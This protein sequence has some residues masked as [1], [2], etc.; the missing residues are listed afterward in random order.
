MKK[1][2]LTPLFDE[3][4]LDRWFNKFKDRAEEKIL[5]LL[6]AAGETFVKYARE[7]GSYNDQTGNLRSSIGY[8]VAK[9]GEILK[10]NFIVS[11]K[12]TDKVTGVKKARQLA[13]DISLSFMGGYILIGVAGMEYAAAVEAK[14][15]NVVTGASILC[16]NY[17]KKSLK[18]I[19]KKMK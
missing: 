18:E 12:G 15:Y 5:I 6:M 16:N 4:D 13:E 19:F 17:L 1:N 9:D 14:G 10:D 3:K 11:D 2:G 7:E 8:I